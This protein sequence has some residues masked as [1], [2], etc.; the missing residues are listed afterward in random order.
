MSGVNLTLVYK[1]PESGYTCVKPLK[2]ASL[3]L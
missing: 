3:M 2:L 1:R